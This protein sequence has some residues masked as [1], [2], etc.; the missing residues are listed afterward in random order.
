MIRPAN[1]A[2]AQAIAKV[3]CDSIY[4]CHAD[5]HTIPPRNRKLDSE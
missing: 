4:A 2:D 3:I 5:H 1:P